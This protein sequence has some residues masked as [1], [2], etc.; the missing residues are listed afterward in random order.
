[1]ECLAREFLFFMGV[2]G[3]STGRVGFG[4]ERVGGRGCA[5]QPGDII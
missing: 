1:M 3:N 5:R 4:G 2:T